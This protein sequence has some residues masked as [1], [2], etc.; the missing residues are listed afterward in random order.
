MELPPARAPRG[1]RLGK[2]VRAAMAG[3]MTLI[4][5]AICSEAT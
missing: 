5:P 2:F 1:A 3:T 4:A